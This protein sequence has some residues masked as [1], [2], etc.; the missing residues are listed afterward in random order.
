MVLS[1]RSSSGASLNSPVCGRVPLGADAVVLRTLAGFVALVALLFFTVSAQAD[2]IE[3]EPEPAP[4]AQPAPEPEPEPEP[5]PVVVSEFEEPSEPRWIPSIETG[6][7]TFDYNVDTTVRNLVTPPDYQ[8]AQNEAERQLMFRIGGELMGP[9]FEDLPGRPRLFVKGGAQFQMFSSDLIFRNGDPYVEDEPESGVANYYTRGSLGKELP[10]VFPGQGSEISARF[11]N[12]SWYAGLGVAFSVPIAT[13]LLLYLK[14]SIQYSVEKIDL[15]GGLTAVEETTP[16]GT[17]DPENCGTAPPITGQPPRP[18]C[19][20][21]FVV[22]RS[23]ATTSTTDHS[24][25]AGLEVALVPFRSARPIRVSLYAEARFLWLVSDDTTEFA[26]SGGV[27]SYSVIRDDF[28]IKGGG[29]LR[30]SW[31][32]YD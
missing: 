27:A 4:I 11:Q 29:G 31:V 19:L 17:V 16:P 28:N 15:P 1:I 23:R 20:R 10:D 9:M 21:E 30:F 18:L 12:P 24:V 14:P 13:N 2:E 3:P 7:E 6:F 8:G 26:D 25:G 32:G 22:H 5:A